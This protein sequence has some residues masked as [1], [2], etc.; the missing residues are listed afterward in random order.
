MKAEDLVLKD[1]FT[2]IILDALEAD[3]IE[4]I[5]DVP[6]SLG[7]EWVILRY[8]VKARPPTYHTLPLRKDI[9]VNQIRSAFRKEI[10]DTFK[11]IEDDN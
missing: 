11:V 5:S 10:D 3:C 8:L 4:K 6:D 9:F 7:E 2:R 1:K